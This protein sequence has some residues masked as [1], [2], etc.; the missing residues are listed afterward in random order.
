M[1]DREWNVG[2]EVWI[3]RVV[4]R[5]TQKPC[6][7]CFGAKRATVILGDDTHVSVGC[8]YCGIGY[9]GPRGYVNENTPVATPERVTLTGR[10]I[11]EGATRTISYRFGG[12]YVL[13]ASAIFADEASALVKAEELAARAKKDA[14]ER[15]DRGGRNAVQKLTW[16]VGYHMREAKRCL[17]SLAHHEERARVL[18]ERIGKRG[19]K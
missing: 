12:G 17:E 10:E 7:V 13:E 3:A 1:T 9:G 4:N 19:K 16:S 11:H 15:S 6:P 8:D 2:D 5:E 18:R 14:D